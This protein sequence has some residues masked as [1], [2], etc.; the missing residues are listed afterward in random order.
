MMNRTGVRYFLY[1]SLGLVV[2]SFIEIPT[3]FFRA[4]I[5]LL[6]ADENS[7][8]MNLSVYPE[9]HEVFCADGAAPLILEVLLCDSS[10]NPI[11]YSRI[12]LQFSHFSARIRPARPITGR[13]GRVTITLYPQ[14]PYLSE[15]GAGLEPVTKTSAAIR[16]NAAK[17]LPV[18]WEGRIA[19]PPVLLVHGFQDTSESMVPLKNFLTEKGLFVF[20]LDYDTNTDL[21]AMADELDEALSGLM[22][23]LRDNG[24]YAQRVDIVAHSLGGLVSRYYTTQPSYLRKNNVHKLVFINVPHHGTPWAEAGAAILNSP[25]LAELYPTS[26][27]YTSL[28]PASIN[29]GLNQ[30]IQTANIALENDEVVPI[31]SSLLTSW[32][33][34]TKVYRIGS[35]PLTFETVI[36]NQITGSSR[37]RQL[38]FYTPVFEEVYHDLT[39]SLSYPQ[40]RK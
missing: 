35:E 7:L 30:T 17:A 1:L 10:Q 13:D 18:L 5:F 29:R 24:I 28:F 3:G 2:F 26:V 33:I 4:K 20:S 38:L 36:S 37:H 23:K 14:E 25:F 34:E 27:L 31:P 8:V 19:N 15:T 16:L 11:P 12:K 21:P 9:E 40:K 32:D 6:F 22:R 39:R